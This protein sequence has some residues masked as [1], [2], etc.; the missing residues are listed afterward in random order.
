MYKTKPVITFGFH[1]L[2]KAKALDIL[3]QKDQFKP[4]KNTYDWLGGGIYFWENSLSRA[5]DYSN[6]LKKRNKINDPFVL[7]AVLDLGNCLDLLD[8]DHVKLLGD[9]YEFLE[10]A[11]SMRSV[12]LPENSPWNN[13]DGDIKKENWTVW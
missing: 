7:G 3:T 9:T 2:D 1:A 11:F 5:E 13:K 4:S 8:L 6:V 10:A 12:D